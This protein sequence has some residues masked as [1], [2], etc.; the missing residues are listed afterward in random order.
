MCIFFVFS[1]SKI[2][3]SETSFLFRI[4]CK[5]RMTNECLREQGSDISAVTHGEAQ[6]PATKLKA[7]FLTQL[8][9]LQHC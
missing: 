2:W 7:I 1:S 4:I 6:A 3:L 8:S 5:R 9:I